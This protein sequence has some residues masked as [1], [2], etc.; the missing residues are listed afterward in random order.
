MQG[1]WFSLLTP[2][3]WLQWVAVLT[4]LRFAAVASAGAWPVLLILAQLAHAVTF[5]A[6]HAACITLV[7]QFFPDRLHGLPR[8]SLRASPFPFLARS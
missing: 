6:H 7:H 5:A 2:P 4:A 8:Q 3:R 1:R